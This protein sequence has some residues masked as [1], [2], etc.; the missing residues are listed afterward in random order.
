MTLDKFTAAYRKWVCSLEPDV[1]VSGVTDDEIGEL[2]NVVVLIDRIPRVRR[3][4]TL[5]RGYYIGDEND[6]D[7]YLYDDGVWRLS[8]SASGKNAFWPTHNAARSFL[9]SL[10]Q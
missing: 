1:L 8:V 10:A 2:F 7:Y 6:H 9:E 5:D 4:P 3:D